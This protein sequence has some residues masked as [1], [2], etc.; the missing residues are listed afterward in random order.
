MLTDDKPYLV[1]RIIH[2]EN[3]TS[4]DIGVVYALDDHLARFLAV[5]NDL[6]KNFQAFRVVD[7]QS[8]EEL[9][10]AWFMRG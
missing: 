5:E 7:L 1:Q 2:I 3:G 10:P 6:I 4:I 9:I 8:Y